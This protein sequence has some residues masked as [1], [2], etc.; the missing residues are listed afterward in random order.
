[1]T[2]EK[3]IKM[4]TD[5]YIK[6]KQNDYVRNPVAYALYKVWKKADESPKEKKKEV[7]KEISAQTMDALNKMGN[8][9][10]GGNNNG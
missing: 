10:H 3:A 4:L 1:M 2:I 5:E 6:A 7:K 8:E 9:V